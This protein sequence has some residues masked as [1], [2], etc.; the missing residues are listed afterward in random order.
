MKLSYLA[1]VTLLFLLPFSVKA[2]TIDNVMALLR[3]GNTAELVKQ[4]SDNVEVTILN[5]DN[6]LDKKSSAP[7]LASFFSQNKP[8]RVKLF[9]RLDSNPDY[10]FAVVLLNT[11]KG[12]Y[13]IAYTLS[14][15]EGMKIIELRIENEKTK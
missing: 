9:H 1:S 14:K 6:I 13:R 2:D 12:T 3:Q 8:V 5:G 10:Q 7:V 15:K 4:F 11:D